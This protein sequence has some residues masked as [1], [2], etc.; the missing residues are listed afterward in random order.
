MNEGLNPRQLP[1][2][3]TGWPGVSFPSRSTVADSSVCEGQTR[4]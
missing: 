3:W 1:R 4:L 2:W